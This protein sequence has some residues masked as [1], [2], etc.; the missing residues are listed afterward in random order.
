MGI[1]LRTEEG[2]KIYGHVAQQDERYW[3]K[4][5]ATRADWMGECVK[6]GRERRELG[7]VLKWPAVS[8]ERC[9]EVVERWFLDAHGRRE[10][11]KTPSVASKQVNRGLLLVPSLLRLC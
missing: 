8:P 9:G 3:Q 2:K 5:S 7:G 4:G 1:E 11:S 10:L 6:D